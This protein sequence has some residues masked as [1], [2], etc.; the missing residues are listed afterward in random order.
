MKV[1]SNFMMKD[2]T[3]DI[4]NFCIDDK[5][6]RFYLGNT[7][8]EVKAFNAS[9][10]LPI[11]SFGENV[12]VKNCE[13]EDLVFAENDQLL[14]TALTNIGIS[15]YDEGNFD[16][17]SRLRRITGG[18]LNSEIKTLGF[19]GHLSL[20]AS[21]AANGSITIW[22]YERSKIKGVCLFHKKEVLALK[23]LDPYPSLISSAADGYICLWSVRGDD[24]SQSYS[25]L[26]CFIN[27]QYAYPLTVQELLPFVLNHK[28]IDHEYVNLISEK[29]LK[30]NYIT[31]L[32]KE[33]NTSKQE[34]KRE[35]FDSKKLIDNLP[36]KE[37]LR[38]FMI[39]GDEIGRIRVW[40]LSQ[41]L[42]YYSIKPVSKY[43]TQSERYNPKRNEDVNATLQARM[44]YQK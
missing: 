8:G 26:C 36:D 22:D 27:L 40:N 20:I 3:S 21:G 25:C 7:A 5:H 1:F 39:T 24:L 28:R 31:F 6:R 34:S 14:I 38:A 10:G 32:N 37:T 29:E 12:V 11:K 13:V 30:Q 33:K 2:K 15:V 23:F 17:V 42:A 41:V 19:S 18:H 43:A 44:I 35:F 9:S 16:S 4:T